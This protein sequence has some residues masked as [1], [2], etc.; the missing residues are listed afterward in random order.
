MS[1]E[2]DRAETLALAIDQGCDAERAAI[3]ILAYRDAVLE[4][5]ANEL[6]KT[7]AAWRLGTREP[8]VSVMAA[9][10]GQVRGLKTKR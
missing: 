7:V 8:N 10:V 1:D 5:A 3:L 2:R 9:M 4:Q 6:S